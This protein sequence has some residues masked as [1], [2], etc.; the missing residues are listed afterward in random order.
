MLPKRKRAPLLVCASLSVIALFVAICLYLTIGLGLHLYLDGG[1]ELVFQVRD[2]YAAPDSKGGSDCAPGRDEAMRV[3]RRRISLAG[4][5]ARVRPLGPDRIKVQVPRAHER[6]VDSVRKLAVRR[7]HLRFGLIV[8]NSHAVTTCGNLP[9]NGSF[10]YECRR[11]VRDDGR[12]EHLVIEFGGGRAAMRTQSTEVY[13]TVDAKGDS[14]LRFRYQHGEGSLLGPLTTGIVQGRLL[15]LIEGAP[16]P[17]DLIKCRAAGSGS[18]EGE[19]SLEDPERWAAIFR[20]GPLS[21]DVILE[22]DTRVGSF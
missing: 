18:I 2:V 3:I 22:L 20:S 11:V 7:G 12:E 4:L 17:K 10:R 1:T 13:P 9:R 8:D 16:A 14:T 21:V 19:I 6:S 5:Y 15:A